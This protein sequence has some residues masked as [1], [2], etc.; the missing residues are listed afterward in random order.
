MGDKQLPRLLLR[1]FFMRLVFLHE[2]S[3]LL[4]QISISVPSRKTSL[5]RT[6][7]CHRVFNFKVLN[8]LFF[9]YLQWLSYQSKGV[10]SSH[11]VYRCLRRWQ[12]RIGKFPQRLL[13]P[14]N[15]KQLR[16]WF[17]FCSTLIFL[18]ILTFTLNA[19]FHCLPVV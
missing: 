6:R 8:S 3:N 15:H 17:K 2:E 12:K 10:W 13:Y 4:K 19:L 18:T 16:H 5:D 14:I 9:L 7:N 11:L 1:T